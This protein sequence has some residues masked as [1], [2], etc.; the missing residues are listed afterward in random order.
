MYYTFRLHEESSQF[1]N[2][3]QKSLSEMVAIMEENFGPVPLRHQRQLVSVDS[4][5]WDEDI[6]RSEDEQE[7]QA[8]IDEYSWFIDDAI[9]SFQHLNAG[10]TRIPR[11]VESTGDCK[12]ISD[13][14]NGFPK[15]DPKDYFRF[16]WEELFIIIELLE[17]PPVIRT[18]NGTTMTALQ[19]LCLL[20]YRLSSPTRLLE[21]QAL[22]KKTKGVVS[23]IFNVM[24]YKIH[25]DWKHLLLFDHVRITP[26][27]TATCSRV[28]TEKGGRINNCFGFLDGT[29]MAV[30]R[31]EEDQEELYNGHKRIHSL[32]YHAISTPDGIIV[33]L[34]GPFSGRRHDSRMLTDSKIMNYLSRH[35]VGEDGKPM[36]I[37]GDE[38]Y[39]RTEHMLSPFRG[40][41][42]TKDQLDF[43]NSMKKPRL[44][45]EWGFGFISNYW[46]RVN[47]KQ[48]LRVGLSPVGLYY[49]VAAFFSNLQRCFGRNSTTQSYYG[50]NTPSIQQYLTKRD[51]WDRTRVVMQEPLYFRDF[52]KIA[53]QEVADHELGPE[54][55]AIITGDR[56][57][58][59]HYYE[60]P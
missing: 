21:C 40:H 28:I 46:G 53:S 57:N 55:G 5:N 14:D 52:E 19:A 4:W 12:F 48:T 45:A 27:F 54:P 47:Y 56:D 39:F 18:D 10:F 36:V 26:E 2:L 17:L 31:P 35:A 25:D 32:K 34:A 30:C 51:V 59:S 60:Q 24:L 1:I 15:R 3:E 8:N 9:D 6:W 23:A 16:T 33:N 29:H 20:L 7:F 37:Y 38:A 41:N 49:P 42:L 50:L 43:N 44:A 22:F 58:A 11:R 13:F